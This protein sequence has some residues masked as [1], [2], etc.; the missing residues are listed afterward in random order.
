MTV[1]DDLKKWAN[2]EADFADSA[3]LLG[4]G[5]S[6]N[7]NHKFSYDDLFKYAGLSPAHQ[8]LF[9]AARAGANFEQTLRGLDLACA[10]AEPL[11]VANDEFLGAARD[12]RKGLIKAVRDRHPE[13]SEYSD[14]QW[15]TI[16]EHLL[17]FRRIYTTNYDL[18]PYWALLHTDDPTFGFTDM[19]TRDCNGVLRFVPSMLSEGTGNNDTTLLYLHGSL[20]LIRD[21]FTDEVSK[22]A[23]AGKKLLGS[24][25]SEWEEEGQSV[26]FVAEGDEESKIHVIE[27]SKYLN[28][29]LQAL[30]EDTGPVVVLGHSLGEADIHIARALTEGRDLT[31]P[32][33][34]VGIYPPDC[35]ELEI[36]R[37]RQLLGDETVLFDSTSHPLIDPAL[38]KLVA[39]A[40]SQ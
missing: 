19:F 35:T 21:L 38:G 22:V 34:A 17:G 6:I 25:S 36:A 9:D 14:A 5:F 8:R 16:R 39:P 20:L 13:K 27:S 40:N 2:V 11:G 26:H 28:F 18:L 32:R 30:R 3:V 29:C 10:M 4:N 15:I 37:L 12:I 33:L 1:V 7:I 23:S 24:I 31:D